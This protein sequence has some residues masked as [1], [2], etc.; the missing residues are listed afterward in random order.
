MRTAI[1]RDERAARKRN[2]RKPEE[3]FTFVNLDPEQCTRCSNVGHNKCKLCLTP[4]CSAKC[5]S[6]DY[7]R[8]RKEC[9]EMRNEEKQ[10]DAKEQEYESCIK[11]L[12]ADN[13]RLKEQSLCKVCLEGEAGVVF[14]PC[15]HLCCCHECSTQLRVCPMCREDV[16]KPIKVFI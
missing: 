9:P 3:E 13:D 11:S 5:K 1:D 14:D 7:S 15:G 8:H 4:Y 2:R 12:R 16:K 10:R 6:K